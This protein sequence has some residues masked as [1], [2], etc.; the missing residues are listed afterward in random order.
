MGK[1]VNAKEQQG[2]DGGCLWDW[3]P[4]WSSRR[5]MKNWE[6]KWTKIVKGGALLS[7]GISGGWSFCGLGCDWSFVMS[8]D[9][10]KWIKG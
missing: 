4:C 8:L 6:S 5:W 2:E 7:V 10:C 3:L 1:E 9:L